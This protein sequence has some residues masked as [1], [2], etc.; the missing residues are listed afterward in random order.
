MTGKNV[1]ELL[2]N[3]EKAAEETISEENKRN[4]LKYRE[5]FFEHA[6]KLEVGKFSDIF[7]DQGNYVIVYCSNRIERGYKS[8]TEVHDEVYRMTMDKQFQV[9]IDRLSESADVQYLD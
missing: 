5:A 3:P 1:D 9:Y 7:I 8:L 4:Y 2:V 6:N